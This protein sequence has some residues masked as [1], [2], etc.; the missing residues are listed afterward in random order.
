M[1]VGLASRLV[2]I[3][4]VP[5]NGPVRPR[6]TSKKFQVGSGAARFDDRI[7]FIRLPAMLPLPRPD[8][9]HLRAAGR[10]GPRALAPYPEQDELG[11]VPEVEADAEPIGAAILPDLMP[12]DVGFVLEAP[13]SH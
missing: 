13:R 6:S 12:D 3:R 4:L 2:F 9:I 8:V 7:L 11:Y 5:P 10:Q 1:A